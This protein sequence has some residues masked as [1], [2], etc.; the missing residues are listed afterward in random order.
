MFKH[1][2]VLIVFSGLAGCQSMTTQTMTPL[3]DQK[4]IYV[5]GL[6]AVASKNDTSIAMIAATSNEIP[7]GQ[8]IQLALQVQ[9]LG[10]N[11]IDIDISNIRV[12]SPK[13]KEVKVYSYAE[14]VKEE[15]QQ[16][17][18][19]LIVNAIAGAA[20]VYSA[21]LNSNVNTSGTYNS[22]TYTPSGTYQTTGTYNSTTYDPLRAQIA[23]NMAANQSANQMN[24]ISNNSDNKLNTLKGSILK[25]TTVFP[26]SAHNGMFVFDAPRLKKDETR[27]YNVQVSIGGELHTFEMLHSM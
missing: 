26:G 3:D 17:A 7:N 8:R 24:R 20:N 13:L 9:N 4:Q 14:L 1:A 11:S 22:S 25:R 15:K 16:R 10:E 23:S 12:T 6:V 19:A 5:D 18:A 2:L 21:S 27:I